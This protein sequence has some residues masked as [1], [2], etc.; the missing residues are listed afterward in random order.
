MNHPSLRIARPTQQ[1][2]AI[3]DMYARGL[4][5]TEL[6]GFEDHQGYDGVM[7]GHPGSCYHLE[8][9]REHGA[10]PEAAPSAEHMLVI[11]EPDPELWAGRC[12]KMESAGFVQ[13]N[14]HNP[15]WQREGRTFRDLD[16]YLVVICRQEWA[17]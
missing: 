15:Y 3:A 10:A 5:M 17:R 6:G 4:D 2:R 8:F 16:G 1:L 12:G 13:V 9:T 14:A 11:Y 7:V